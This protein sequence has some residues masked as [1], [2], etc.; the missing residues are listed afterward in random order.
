MCMSRFQ[1]L[2]KTQRL[3]SK[4]LQQLLYMVSLPIVFIE[5]EM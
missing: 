4:L 5:V 3:A 2:D 1:K